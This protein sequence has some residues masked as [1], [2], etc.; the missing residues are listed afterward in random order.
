MA[1][2]SLALQT[3]HYPV[4]AQLAIVVA[5]DIDVV[6]TPNAAAVVPNVDLADMPVGPIAVASLLAHPE[7]GQCMES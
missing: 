6:E 1:V 3:M 7:I 5:P 4:V 2:P